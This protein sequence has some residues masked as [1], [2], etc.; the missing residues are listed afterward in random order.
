MPVPP[1]AHQAASAVAF[2]AA[3]HRAALMAEPNLPTETVGPASR[4]ATLQVQETTGP[5]NND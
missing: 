2:R 5:N 4:R 3:R 1:S